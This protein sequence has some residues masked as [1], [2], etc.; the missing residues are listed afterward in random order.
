MPRFMPHVIHS[1]YAVYIYPRCTV[2][3]IP[4]YTCVDAGGMHGGL[5]VGRLARDSLCSVIA[6]H[7]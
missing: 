7:I 6:I 3:D 1:V 5:I 4:L 2:Y